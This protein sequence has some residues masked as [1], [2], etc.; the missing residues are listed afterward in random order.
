MNKINELYLKYKKMSKDKKSLVIMMAIVFMLLCYALIGIVCGWITKSMAEI[1][2]KT[3]KSIFEYMISTGGLLIT[4]SMCAGFTIIVIVYLLR[5]NKRN[6]IET[7]DERGVSFMKRGTLG[8]SRW[9]TDEEAKTVFNVTNAYNTK[10]TI[11]GQLTEDGSQVVSYKKTHEGAV[12][13]KNNFIIG[14]PGTGK[15]Y[16]FVRT[17]LLQT[18]DRGG[19]FFVT[20]PKG[21]LCKDLY[22]YCK[23]KGAITSV[24]NL[25]D[26]SYTDCWNCLSETINAETERVDQERL[27]QFV[28][29]YMKNASSSDE[30]GESFWYNCAKNL[31]TAVIGYVAYD[32]ERY[33]IE[34]YQRVYR[35]IAALD[36]NKEK[37]IQAM[38]KASFKKSRELILDAARRYKMDENKIQNLLDEIKESAPKY[39]IERAYKALLE[40][41]ESTSDG[42]ATI[43]D[44]HPAKLAYIIYRTNDTDNVRGAALQGA[45]MK[46]SIFG[47]DKLCYM[48]S[49]DGVNLR[50]VNEKQT[51]VFLI[52]N[53]LNTTMKPIASLI[54]TFLFTDAQDEWDRA[55]QK[56][57]KEKGIYNNKLPVTIMLD[58]FFSLGVLGGDP[59]KFATWMSVARA[60]QLEVS[61]I[62][63]S[64]SQVEALYGKQLS[65]TIQTACS[66]IIFLGTNDQETANWIS[67]FASGE[68]TVLSEKHKEA[69]GLLFQGGG[70]NIEAGVQKR[71][72]ITADEARCWKGKVLVVKQGEHPLQLIPFPWVMHPKY[73]SG[74]IREASVYDVI[75]PI[76]NKMNGQFDCEDKE[77]QK[78]VND[79]ISNIQCPYK[80]ENGQVV[81]IEKKVK[82][83]GIAQ[84]ESNGDEEIASSNKEN[85]RKNRGANKA[86]AIANS[87]RTKPSAKKNKN[88]SELDS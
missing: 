55:V 28:D 67:D 20:D 9:M 30:K 53:D 88:S 72:L 51:A 8:T 48:L 4:G 80:I 69:G 40:F 7:T 81:R 62:L 58:E 54:T 59:A 65:N 43:P 83:K 13:N 2:V 70:N 86:K 1:F 18:I 11:Y 27:T 34:N 84:E 64:H 41:N 85:L 68:A 22:L 52:T 15:S 36:T 12:G 78:K 3:N 61:I 23:N 21:D 39:T 33:I 60:R 31:L 87:L 46:M 25:Q 56:E 75:E 50:N 38:V 17:E 32:R 16:V 57:N 14:P 37:V 45:L 10:T 49:H 19:S 47:N 44:W 79:E 26:L 74:D 82:Q 24:L 66:N 73:I 5:I 77:L 29:V 35:N 76:D 6:D 42:F 63:Q 71:K